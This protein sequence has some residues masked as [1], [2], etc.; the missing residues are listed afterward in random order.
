RGPARGTRR[1]EL[2]RAL[3]PPSDGPGLA[4]PGRRRGSAAP[5]RRAR[6]AAARAGRPA[7]ARPERLSRRPR[8]A[9]DA[10]AGA[11]GHCRQPGRAGPLGAA[12]GGEEADGAGLVPTGAGGATLALLLL[13][14][15]FAASVGGARFLL[16]V[17]R[18]AAVLDRPNQR[19]SHDV[20]TPRGGGI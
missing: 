5:A 6:L 7:G 13:P 19:S 2:R 9:Q 20:A 11:F 17:L 18:R 14:A 8:G 1:R 15:V 10:A 3:P 4:H 16:A 12:A